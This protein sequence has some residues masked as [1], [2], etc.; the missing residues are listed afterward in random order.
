[1]CP[2]P[3]ISSD[4][5]FDV[6]SLLPAPGHG[7]RISS[8]VASVLSGLL[9]SQRTQ[10]DINPA[11]FAADAGA[12]FCPK[13][14]HQCSVTGPLKTWPLGPDLLPSAPFKLADGRIRIEWAKS[15]R[16]EYLSLLKFE[17]AKIVNVWILP[18]SVA[19]K[20]RQ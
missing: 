5:R 11:L 6:V 14:S 18:A 8:E 20:V 7:G 3:V 19:V 1:M 2:G 4:G 16:I 10:T 17:G 15:G 9:E 12:T 13:W